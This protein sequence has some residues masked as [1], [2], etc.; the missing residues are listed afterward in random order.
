MKIYDI[1][2][3]DETLKTCL[4]VELREPNDSHILK[5]VLDSFLKSNFSVKINTEIENISSG[6]YVVLLDGH[7]FSV[8]Q[9]DESIESIKQKWG[10]QRDA[11]KNEIPF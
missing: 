11:I 7:V 6:L 10:I 4:L 1:L 3:K 2:D 9:T 8:K 5:L